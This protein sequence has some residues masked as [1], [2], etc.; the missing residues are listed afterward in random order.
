MTANA[1]KA[2]YGFCG[3]APLGVNYLK[4]TA[5]RALSIAA[6]LSGPKATYF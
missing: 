3:L 1:L 4:G 2:F 6:L 5:L